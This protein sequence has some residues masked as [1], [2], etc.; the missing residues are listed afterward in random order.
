VRSSREGVPRASGLGSGFTQLD[1]GLRTAGCRARLT[2]AV[3]H[4]PVRV[5]QDLGKFLSH[6]ANCILDICEIRLKSS[7]CAVP[8]GA[9]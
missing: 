7:S 5:Y 2:E 1:S 9:V 8:T 6:A 4:F 3:G